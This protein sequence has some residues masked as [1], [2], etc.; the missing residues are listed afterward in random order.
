MTPRP[1]VLCIAGTRPEVIKMAPVV[2]RLQQPDS[3]LAVTLCIT[4]QHRG[5]TD[6]VLRV[7]GLVPDVD[8][9]LMRP[10]QTLPE[11]TS[12]LFLRL[13]DLF[14][15]TRPD[16]V[17]VQGDTTSAMVGAMSAFYARIKVGH[18]E[19][20][21]RTGNLAEPF[22]E[23]MNRAVIGRVS[24]LHFAPTERARANLVAEAIPPARILVTGNTAIDALRWAVGR[25][26][27]AEA[28]AID[29]DVPTILVTLHRRESFGEPMAGM[30]R[31]IRDVAETHR[32]RVRFICPVHP[33]PNVGPVMRQI[34][35]DLPN[36]TLTAPL[37]YLSTVH[38]LARC[39]FVVTDSGGIQEEAPSLGKP[40]LVLRNTTER[41]EGVDA[42]TARLVGTDR[43][44]VFDAITTLLTDEPAYVRMANAVSPYGDGT[45][46]DRIVRALDAWQE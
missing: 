30:C 3:P 9:D 20:G 27:P 22:P 12:A 37:D 23:E 26:Q 14:A 43:Q 24:D 7:F 35:G 34:L 29:P 32:D 6:D 40:V 16:W 25:P 17:L 28:P 18:V 5:L 44:A 38:T 13:G 41:P 36:V 39:R 10:G 4:A 46:A 33:N 19:A 15:K 21:L 1:T 8:L 11:L 2:Q 42:G 31:A 45:A